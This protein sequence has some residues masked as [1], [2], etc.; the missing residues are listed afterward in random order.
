MVE[1]RKLFF[2]FP[3]LEEQTKIA[4]FLSNVDEKI[5]QLTQKHAL[6]SQY[7]QGMMQKLRT[8]TTRLVNAPKENA[9]GQQVGQPNGLRQAQQQ[10]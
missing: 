6:L 3:S 9:N 1:L 4:S 10:R 8:K 2:F 5:S 7:K